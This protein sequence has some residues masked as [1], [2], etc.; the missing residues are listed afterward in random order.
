MNATSQ[1]AHQAHAAAAAHPNPVS[2]WARL[3]ALQAPAQTFWAQ[4]IQAIGQ[5]LQARRVLLLV[6]G[7]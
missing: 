4:Y 1:K 3:A 7:I 2:Q 5:G 6:S